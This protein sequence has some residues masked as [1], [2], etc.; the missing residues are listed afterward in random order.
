MKKRE[1]QQRWDGRGG[2]TSV[3]RG[4]KLRWKEKQEADEEEG[5]LLVCRSCRGSL[6]FQRATNLPHQDPPLGIYFRVSEESIFRTTDLWVEGAVLTLLGVSEVDRLCDI[7]LQVMGSHGSREVHVFGNAVTN[8][9]DILTLRQ[10]DKRDFA[11]DRVREGHSAT[12]W[13][14][15]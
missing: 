8:S 9:M 5:P 2:K 10:S 12:K 4:G 7:A 15:V 11:L 1:G 13:E 3:D 6:V 14:G